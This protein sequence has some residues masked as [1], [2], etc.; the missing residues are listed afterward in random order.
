MAFV[1]CFFGVELV[2]RVCGPA[3]FL[4]WWALFVGLC[5]LWGLDCGG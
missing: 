2:F 4:K 5:G 1:Y 3:A